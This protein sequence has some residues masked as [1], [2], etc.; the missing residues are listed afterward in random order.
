[1]PKQN[2]YR[3]KNAFLFR[4]AIMKSDFLMYLGQ[5][6]VRTFSQIPQQKL[7]PRQLFVERVYNVLVFYFYKWEVYAHERSVSGSINFPLFKGVEV[8]T[9][10]L[11]FFYNTWTIIG[12][13]GFVINLLNRLDGATVSFRKSAPEKESLFVRL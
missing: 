13:V 5:G 1:M 12:F 4:Y 10:T 3:C 8:F 2:F 6:F 7:V 11:E 9:F